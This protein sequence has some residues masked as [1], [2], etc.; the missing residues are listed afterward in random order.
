MAE[1]TIHEQNAAALAE[2]YAQLAAIRGRMG[3]GLTENLSTN[4]YEIQGP[5]LDENDYAQPMVFRAYADMELVSESGTRV[6][7]AML[8]NMNFYP[9]PSSGVIG[10]SY[11]G[12]VIAS[13]ETDPL[14]LS[15]DPDIPAP[16]G[17]KRWWCM[18]FNEG[19]AAVGL[20]STGVTING[21]LDEVE[22]AAKE[23]RMVSRSSSGFVV[24]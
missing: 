21:A 3:M 20:T 6:H 5:A 14:A 23:T 15:L 9:P 13:Q 12:C 10:E 24:M 11:N 2:V 16:D 17:D 18:I 19:D 4:G 7:G 8:P 1:P 22:I